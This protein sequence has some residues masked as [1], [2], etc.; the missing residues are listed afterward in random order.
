MHRFVTNMGLAENL[1][2]S[3]NIVYEVLLTAG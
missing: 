2:G 1:S 3:F